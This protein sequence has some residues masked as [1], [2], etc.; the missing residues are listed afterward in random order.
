[1]E[2]KSLK[3]DSKS[4]ECSQIFSS[5]YSFKER[6]WKCFRSTRIEF[7]DFL[8]RQSI[9]Q[10]YIFSVIKQIS[11]IFTT[12]KKG[13]LP[14]RK[15]TK[16]CQQHCCEESN[17]FKDQFYSCRDSE[18]CSDSTS[19]IAHRS[20]ETSPPKT[21]L[22]AL[23]PPKKFSKGRKGG[24]DGASTSSYSLNREALAVHRASVGRMIATSESADW[25][26]S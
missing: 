7:Q 11:D 1:M 22:Y 13:C 25:G 17:D 18:N 26:R 21:I 10:K 3:C 12:I 6:S 9:I 23:P 5:V 19:S 8:R 4:L 20:P 14:F 15:L 16:M 2:A 24:A